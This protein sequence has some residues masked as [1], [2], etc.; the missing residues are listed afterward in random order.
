MPDL[1]GPA[2]PGRANPSML[3]VVPAWNEE[4]AI[5]STIADIRASPG[6]EVDVL[7]VD[8]GSTD[9]TAARA[10]ATGARVCSL[11]YNLG[12]GGA[13]RPGYRYAMRHTYDVVVQID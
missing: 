2:G 10:V 13:M 8:A 1:S 5:A 4:G 6:A 3:V 11:P 9:D 7:V 12:V